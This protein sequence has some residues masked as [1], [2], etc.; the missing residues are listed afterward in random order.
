MD[1]HTDSR[2]VSGRDFASNDD[3]SLARAMAVARYLVDKARVP[4]DKVAV[5]AY[6][7]SQPLVPNTTPEGLRMNRRV[8]LIFEKVS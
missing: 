1:G 4:G 8:E 6:G 5:G 2:P 3:L 7:D